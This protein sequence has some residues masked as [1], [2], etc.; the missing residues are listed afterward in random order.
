MRVLW[1]SPWLRPLARIHAENLHALGAEVMLVTRDRHP[2]S[3]HARPYETVLLGRP[4]PT[5]DWWPV[6][7]AYRHAKQFQPDIV[8]TELLGDPRWRIFA[9]LAPRI[10]LAHDDLP[11]DSTHVAPWWKGFFF[12]RWDE[13]AD[14]TVVFSNYVADSLRRRMATRSRLY[15]A[16]LISDLSP[17]LVPG[18]VPAQERRNIIM[19]GRQRP[20]K[21]HQVVFQAWEAHT[22]GG[23]W[24]GDELI[25]FGMGE[26][27][28]PLPSHA[29][30]EKGP[31]QY[32]DVVG[33]L[34]RA[35]ASI[36]HSRRASQSGVQILSMQLGVA[37]LVSTAGALPENQP[38]GL[39]PI[40]IDDVD[41]LSRAMD[42]LADP[43][44]VE[45]QGK[46]A[47]EHFRSNFEPRIA[48]QRLLEIFEDVRRSV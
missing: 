41:G 43:L 16:P 17:A 46:R 25:L 33:E 40:G 11:H 6:L 44:E 18:F 3:D 14:A 48:A 22:Q 2:E 23:A 9:R 27:A 47:L 38:D 29:R 10:R 34:A 39:S 30:W 36:V 20:Y 42:M 19:V 7:K 24:P 21:N 32:K 8:V 45:I 35:R 4:I 31:F 15:V 5:S 1:L 37:T 28:C 13:E 26:I 12:E